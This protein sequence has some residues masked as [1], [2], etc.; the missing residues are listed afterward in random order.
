MLFD[1]TGDGTGANRR[2][3]ISPDGRFLLLKLP[4]AR[5][6]DATAA[7]DLILVQNWFDELKR[8]VPTDR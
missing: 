7:P 3:D 8:L 2:V 1:M 6:D 4:G 5:T